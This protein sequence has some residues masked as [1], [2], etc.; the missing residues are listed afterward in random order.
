MKAGRR[1]IRLMGTVIDCLVYHEEAER[2]LDETVRLLHLYERRFSANRSDSELMQINHQAGLAPVSVS[3]DLYELIR[4]GKEHSC[5]PGSR[6][7]IAI[8]PLVQ[9]W[10]I[11]FSDASVPSQL[12]I[13][14][15]RQLIDPEQI[16]LKDA[17]RSVF[18]KKKGMLI[19]LG[20]LA[21]G[22]IADKIM[23]YLK[24]EKATAA[25]INLGGNVLTW[26]PALHNDD[27][28]WRV[29]I[30]NP[31]EKRGINSLVLQ[32]RSRSVVTSGIYERKLEAEGR[33]YHHI[34]SSETGYPAET[35]TAS[36]TIFSD[37]SVD[38][39]IWT[40]RLFGQPLEYIRQELAGQVHLSGLVIKKNGEICWLN[41]QP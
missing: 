12:A 37:K 17:E 8:G 10:R 4:L 19:D 1:Q 29:G 39:E 31:A 15:K 7:N 13:D 33:T 40:T 16:I 27:Q 35:D 3:P 38:G 14:K 9:L 20:A 6:L 23:V 32:I 34:L 36:L 22:Y 18:L 26:G 11:G 28:L 41:G 25:L 21:K 5:A 30:Q 24:T 2:L